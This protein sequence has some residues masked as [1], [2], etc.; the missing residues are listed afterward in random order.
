MQSVSALHLLGILRD[1]LVPILDGVVRSPF[2][3]V[4]SYV[5]ISA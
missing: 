5:S 2:A 3:E 4:V 1:L